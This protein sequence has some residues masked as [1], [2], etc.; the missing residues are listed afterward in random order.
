LPPNHHPELYAEWKNMKIS[1]YRYEKAF[2]CWCGPD[3]MAKGQKE[4]IWAE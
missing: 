4:A 3:A 2:K 1:G